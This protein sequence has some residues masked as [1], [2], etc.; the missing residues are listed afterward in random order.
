MRVTVWSGDR[1]KCLGEGELVGHVKVW[2]FRLPD[3]TLASGT[4]C[5]EMPPRE[6]IREMEE[7]GAR[8]GQLLSNPKI[9]LDT[10]EVVYGCQVW[11]ER[12]S[13]GR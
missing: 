10:G 11:W 13:N 12:K 5:E 4:M 1:S 8:L 3:G 9:M 7:K 6:L 2:C